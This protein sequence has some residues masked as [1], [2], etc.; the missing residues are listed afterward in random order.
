MVVPVIT[1]NTC[2]TGGNVCAICGVDLNVGVPVFGFSGGNEYCSSL[3]AMNGRDR[4]GIEATAKTSTAEWIEY[5]Q[6]SMQE[7]CNEGSLRHG[8]AGLLCNVAR[9]LEA[10]TAKVDAIAERMPEF[11]E[12]CP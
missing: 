9:D 11:V 7:G 3:C 4:A 1:A 6:R 12:D 2:T 10:L 8:I 5:L